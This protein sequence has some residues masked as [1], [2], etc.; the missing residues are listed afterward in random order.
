MRMPVIVEKRGCTVVTAASA[1][2]ARQAHGA[3][4]YFVSPEEWLT[5]FGSDSTMPLIDEVADL[6]PGRLI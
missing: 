3:R 1:A 6:P 5:P 2:R 4:K